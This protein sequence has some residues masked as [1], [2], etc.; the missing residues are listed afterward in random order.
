ML[1]SKDDGALRH[2]YSPHGSP[3]NERD[4][5][6]GEIDREESLSWKRR[7]TVD[8]MPSRHRDT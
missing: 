8:L 1:P 5:T 4:E 7:A 6:L 3:V 2:S